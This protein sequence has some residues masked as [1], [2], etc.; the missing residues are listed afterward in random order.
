[1]RALISRKIR[2][3]QCSTGEWT[4][5]VILDAEKIPQNTTITELLQVLFH[6]AQLTTGFVETCVHFIGHAECF[7][8]ALACTVPN[9]EARIAGML[10]KGQVL[11]IKGSLG[12][13]VS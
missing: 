1:M 12:C 3:A 8:S 2:N 13:F 4:L 11:K 9:H 6:V 5:K 10:Q 7:P